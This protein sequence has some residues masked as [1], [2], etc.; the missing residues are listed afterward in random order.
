MAIQFIG[1]QILFDSGSIAFHEDCCCG[2]SFGCDNCSGSVPT[3]LEVSIS[4]V[5][6]SCTGGNCGDLNTDNGTDDVPYVLDITT[7]DI[8]GDCLWVYVLDP[9]ECTGSEI[10]EQIEVFLV[11]LGGGQYELAIIIAPSSG[12]FDNNFLWWDDEFS[13][14]EDCAA[15]SD[16]DVPFLIDGGDCENDNSTATITAV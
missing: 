7:P 8:P 5:A 11:H 13:P 6:G 4:G 3:Q 1:G 14:K 10:L 16:R 2:T 9:S 15:W 12:S